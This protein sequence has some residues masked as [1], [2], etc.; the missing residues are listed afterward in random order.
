MILEVIIDNEVFFDFRWRWFGYIVGFIG[1]VVG[2]IQ[3]LDG[4][5]SFIIREVYFNGEGFRFVIW[6]TLP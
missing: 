4:I 6:V 2:T 1:L 3:F 5:V